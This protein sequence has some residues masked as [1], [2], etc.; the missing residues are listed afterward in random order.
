MTADFEKTERAVM[1][2]DVIK[3]EMQRTSFDASM[4]KAN[5]MN[6]TDRY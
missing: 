3:I 6:I 2:H 5:E 4:N 1:A